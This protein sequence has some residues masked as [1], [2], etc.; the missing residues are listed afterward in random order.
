MS[1]LFS[2]G[3]DAVH[4]NVQ[5]VIDGHMRLERG[6]MQAISAMF[7]DDIVWHEFGTSPLAG[8][9][10]GI[11]AVLAYWRDYF[12]AAGATFNQDIT[13]IMANDDYVTSI[14]HMTGQK[15]D[16]TFDQT[17]VDIMRM[18]GG[19]IVEFWRYY[20]DVEEAHSFILAKS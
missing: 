12:D 8:S 13:Q 4:P 16:R 17:A 9:F 5:F 18:G 1:I 7:A 15:V 11:D 19:K 3:A 14:V 2:P 10:S 20:A 6:D